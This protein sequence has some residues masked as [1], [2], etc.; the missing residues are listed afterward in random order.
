M[1][2]FRTGGRIIGA[3]VVMEH[4][5]GSRTLF[6]LDRVHS[7][8]I[9]YQYDHYDMIGRGLGIVLV[10]TNIRLEVEASAGFV[11]S[12][13]SGFVAPPQ[14]PSGIYLPNMQFHALPAPEDG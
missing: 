12:A 5:D 1:A 3:A 9:E 8:T 2:T 13:G 4:P 7:A 10:G 14:L 6:G 11:R